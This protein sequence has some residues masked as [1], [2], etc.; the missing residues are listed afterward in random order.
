MKTAT[1]LADRLRDL[2]SKTKCPSYERGI[3]N[4]A[5]EML[6][7][8]AEQIEQLTKERNDAYVQSLQFSEENKALLKANLDCFDNFNTLKADY[9]ALKADAERYK[10]LKQRL[11]CA[12]FSYGE[13]SEGRNALVF[14]IPTDMRVSTDLDSSIDAMKGKS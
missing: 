10:W 4:G 7:Q 1:E 6:R 9:D 12:D 11:L 13:P 8:Q 2:T 14:E 5:I 3:M